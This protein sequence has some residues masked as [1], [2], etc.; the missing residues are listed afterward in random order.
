MRYQRR[1]SAARTR[2]SVNWP[3]VNP[4]DCNPPAKPAVGLKSGFGFTSS[5]NGLP[6]GRT[7]KST[8]A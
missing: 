6:E 8:R 5:K 3:C 4:A 1:A 2:S 7:R